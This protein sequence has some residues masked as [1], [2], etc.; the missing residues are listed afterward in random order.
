MIKR[1]LKAY[2]AVFFILAMFWGVFAF[3]IDQ[4]TERHCPTMPTS[5]S[6]GPISGAKPAKAGPRVRPGPHAL[7]RKVSRQPVGRFD[8]EITPSFWPGMPGTMKGGVQ[9]F[10]KNGA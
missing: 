10:K 1:S 4:Q 8:L 7:V 9:D 6:K 3:H 2:N 5:Q